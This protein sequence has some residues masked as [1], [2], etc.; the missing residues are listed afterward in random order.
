MKAKTSIVI[1]CGLIGILILLLADVGWAQKAKHGGTLTVVH[2]VDIAHLDI[3]T[4]PGYEMMWINENVHN[5]LVTLDKDLNIVPDVAKSWE[6]S[7]D[8]R[9]YTFFLQEGVKF[10]DGSD[11]DAEAVKWNFEDYLN[12]KRAS[13]MRVYFTGIER[14]EVVDKHTVRIILKEPNSFFLMILAGY[15]TGFL[16]ISPAVFEKAGADAYRKHPVGSGPFKF[17]EWVP[18]DH[19]TLVRNEHYWKK[20]LPYLDKVVFRV[21]SDPMTQVSALKAREVDLINS[22]SPELVRVV[23]KDRNLT[24]LTGPE[25]TPMVA[26]FNVSKPPFDDLRVRKAIGC[27][28]IDRIE[29]VQKALLGLAT[30]MVGFAGPGVQGYVDLVGMCPYN[31]EQARALLKE[32]GYDEKN[33]LRFSITTNSEKAVFANIGTLLKSQY[34]KLGAEAKVDV[35]DKVTWMAEMVGKLRCTWDQTVEDLLALLTV[36]N[37][38][39]ILE[40]ASSWNLACH[41]DTKLDEYHRRLERTASADERQKLSE[42]FQ[43]YMIENMYW[44]SVSGSPHYKVHRKHVK[45]FHFQAEFKFL[46]EQVWL[47]K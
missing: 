5:G 16:M 17:Q 31:P 11:L 30:P 6:V 1:G 20:G 46:L 24:V 47:D 26:L 41:N 36:H 21:L 42:E 34:A 2:A 13:G 27:Y 35:K 28:G 39:H 40:A 15:R 22:L 29:I 25:T 12:P 19:V 8:G 3:H 18:N 33:P 7:P 32:A 38:L 14:V 44:A 4:A 45:D 10:H 37:N 23:E 9:T 43:R